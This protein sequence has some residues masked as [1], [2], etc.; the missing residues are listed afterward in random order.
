MR[1]IHTYSFPLIAL[2]CLLP[3]LNG[4]EEVV[5]KVN[6]SD[7]E[8]LT[9]QVGDYRT[10]FKKGPSWTMRSVYYRDVCINDSSGGYSLGTV[11]KERHGEDADPFLGSGHRP[12]EI[13]EFTVSIFREDQLIEKRAIEPGLSFSEGNRVVVNKTSNFISQYNGH[14][15]TLESAVTISAEGIE[16][17]VTEVGGDGDLSKIVFVYPFMH[18]LPN[19]TDTYYAFLGDTFIESGGFLTD[20]SMTLKKNITG[21]LAFDPIHSLG[22]YLYHRET[23]SDTRLFIFNRERDHK[24]YFRYPHPAKEGQSLEYSVFLQAFPASEISL[25][26]RKGFTEISLP[27]GNGE[28]SIYREI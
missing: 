9:I 4:E 11:L 20:K 18:M 22:I 2:V 14:L 16:Q 3:M 21:L 15:L 5:A 1:F 10:S 6:S 13:Q 8:T 17:T 25:Q 23:Y 28:I 24:L 27:S 19:A 12:E 26:P 7:G